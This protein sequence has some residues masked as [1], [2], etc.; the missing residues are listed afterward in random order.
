MYYT[1]CANMINLNIS[2]IKQYF[3]YYNNFNK[4]CKPENKCI[5]PILK[6]KDKYYIFHDNNL[7]FLNESQP[8]LKYFVTYD[9]Q[10]FLI[11]DKQYLYK[12][13]DTTIKEDI[14]LEFN[15]YICVFIFVDDNLKWTIQKNTALEE[16]IFYKQIVD[17]KNLIQFNF[18]V[19]KETIFVIDFP[20][21]SPHNIVSEHENIVTDNYVQDIFWDDV[22]LIDYNSVFE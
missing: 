9:K 7:E 6:I 20:L 8:G 13:I 18:V 2:T 10:N 1:L 4:S 12:V 11:Y 22:V 15:E 3:W 16:N 19:K 17:N 21:L 5:L 14:L